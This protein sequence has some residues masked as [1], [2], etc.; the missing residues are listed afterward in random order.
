MTLTYH[1]SYDERATTLRIQTLSSSTYK[2]E[3][4]NMLTGLSQ[5]TADLCQEVR[6]IQAQ[7][8]VS[9]FLLSQCK[10]QYLPLTPRRGVAQYLCR[11]ILARGT[12]ARRW[13]PLRQLLP[14]QVPST[15]FSSDVVD[16][17]TRMQPHALP[18][19]HLAPRLLGHPRFRPSPRSALTAPACSRRL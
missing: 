13:T 18:R 2:E 11:D 3:I 1:L 10:A 6:V 9:S 12:V 8:S 15:P 5:Q 16:L 17:H 14:L 19:S 7:I 4:R